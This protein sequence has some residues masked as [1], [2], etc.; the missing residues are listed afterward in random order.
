MDASEWGARE[1]AQ[2]DTVDERV[3]QAKE[4]AENLAPALFGKLR[5]RELGDIAHESDD[6]RSRL[7]AL[8]EAARDRRWSTV[9]RL[10]EEV[11]ALLEVAH[12]ES[13]VADAVE[14]ANR[15]VDLEEL[16]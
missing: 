10:S 6:A 15:P 1:M 8:L 13:M 4:R 16:A 12:M 5:A 7:D 9:Q 3:E 14:L 2:Q 11:V